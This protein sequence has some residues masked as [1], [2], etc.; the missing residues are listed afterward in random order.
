MGTPDFATCALK[1]LYQTGEYDIEVVTQPDKP[2]GRGYELMPPDVKVYALSVGLPVYQPSTLKDG[3]FENELKR[4]NPDIIVVAAYGKILPHYVISYPKYGCINIHG[5][6]LP[7]YRGAAP[8]QRAIIDGKNET[9]ITV[10]LMDDGLDTGDILTV[11]KVKIEEGDDFGTLFDKMAEAGANAIVSSLPDIINGKITPIKQDGEKSTYAEKIT[12]DDCNI[13]FTKP[14]KAV[15]DLIRGLSPMPLGVI[16]REDGE[17]F[18]ITSAK[19]GG[20]YGSEPK[21]AVLSSDGLDVVC[22]DGNAVTVTSFIP[23]GKKK[24]AVSDYFRGHK[25][26]ASVWKIL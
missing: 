2:K 18:K 22:G 16:R 25:F 20:K 6:L 11:T 17:V 26:D 1:A 9:G 13:D 19:L 10:M 7:E 5:S 21:T 12:K 8:V 24:M 3:A 23:A 4:I 14:A 15:Y